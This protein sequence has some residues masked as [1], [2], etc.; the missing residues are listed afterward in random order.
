MFFFLKLDISTAK[1]LKDLLIVIPPA[2]M[3]TGI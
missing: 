2:F 1:Y 3:P